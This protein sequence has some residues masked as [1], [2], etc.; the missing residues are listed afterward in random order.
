A[1]IAILFFCANFPNRY[2]HMGG[3][4]LRFDYIAMLIFALVAM[5]KGRFGIAGACVAWAT[6]E[7]LFPAIFAVG[8]AYKAGVELLATRKLR[9]EYLAFGIGFVATGLILFFLSLTLSESL[10]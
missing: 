8:L 9:K 6:A 1:A 7:R 10:G 4:I 5:K 3:S 2:L